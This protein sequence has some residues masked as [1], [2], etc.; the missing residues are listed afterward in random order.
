[1]QGR[2]A[3]EIRP[4]DRR[5]DDLGVP[6]RIAGISHPDHQGIVRGLTE[7]VEYPGGVFKDMTW[8]PPGETF[9]FPEDGA[10]KF[11]TKDFSE[12]VRERWRFLDR[13]L[14]G[15][16]AAYDWT[17]AQRPDAVLVW[18]DAYPETRGVIL[19][20][21]EL[22][23]PSIEIIHGHSH[24]IRPGDTLAK[25]WADWKLGTAGYADWHSFHGLKS[26]VLRTGSPSHDFYAGANLPALRPTA[27][28]ELQIDETATIITYL[29][30]ATYARSAWSS[31]ATTSGTT[32]E[33]LKA[34]KVLRDVIPD[35][36]L[37]VKMHPGEVG[38]IPLKAYEK[39]LAEIGITD[40]YTIMNSELFLALGASDLVIGVQTSAF[41]DALMLE[42]PCVVL[43]FEPWFAEWVYQR[44]GC[45]VV[46]RPAEILQSL[47][48]ILLGRDD[49]NELLDDVT[50]GA[51]YFA[52]AVDGR[53][54]DR[55]LRAISKILRKEDPNDCQYGEVANRDDHPGPGDVPSATR[56]AL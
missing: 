17:K 8:E 53:A 46:R 37:I 45:R 49:M 38:K 43:G 19:A 10:F 15:A 5:S 12:S 16:E 23:I 27:R 2:E 6:G 56:E 55:T 36:H 52:G 34:V 30:D 25:D 50:D 22:G 48:E 18:N 32:L 41:A 14:R 7:F 33:F 4:D 28:H 26:K 39:V 24:P 54:T 51:W 9:G 1:M 13:L 40:N 31:E 20:A 44:K 29:C 3:P 47:T 21:R 35:L 42:I 11:L